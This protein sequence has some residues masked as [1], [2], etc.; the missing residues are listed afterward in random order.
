M[1]SQTLKCLCP[2]P[3]YIQW[4]DGAG[5][6]TQLLTGFGT[7][8]HGKKADKECKLCGCGLCLECAED[9][10]VGI[11]DNVFTVFDAVCPTCAKEE[12]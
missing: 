8:L 6:H 5:T 4:K 12:Q 1:I 9:F 2:C 11:R 10:I 7:V 3:D